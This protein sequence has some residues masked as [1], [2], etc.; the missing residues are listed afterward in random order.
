MASPKLLAFA[1]SLRKSSYNLMLVKVAA[2]GAQA[3]GAEVKVISLKDYPMPVY[4]QDWFDE[5][6]FPESVLQF[7][8]LLK[9]HDGFF[10]CLSGIQWLNFW[11]IKECC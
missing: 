9:A 4:D 8:A 2:A 10:D 1:G 5:H 3:A 6:G 7:K 11:G